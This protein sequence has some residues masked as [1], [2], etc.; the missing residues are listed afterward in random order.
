[1][2][3]LALAMAGVWRCD[4]DRY[5][6]GFDQCIKEFLTCIMA[7]KEGFLSFIHNRFTYHSADSKIIWPVKV[8]TN[9]MA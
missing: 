4:A 3:A 6:P 9:A 7:E 5:H 1:M 8:W 2:V